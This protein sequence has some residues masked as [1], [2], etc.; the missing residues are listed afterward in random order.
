MDAVHGTISCGGRWCLATE[1]LETEKIVVPTETRLD[2]ADHLQRKPVE[3]LVAGVSNESER[4][5]KACVA[6]GVVVRS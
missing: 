4:T 3:I 6:F 1:P 5:A 2:A